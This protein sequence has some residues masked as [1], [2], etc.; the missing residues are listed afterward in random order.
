[1]AT[2]DDKG[3]VDPKKAEELA[4]AMQAAKFAADAAAQSFQRQLDIVSQLRD[5][6]SEMSATMEKMSQ[7]DTSTAFA[8]DKLRAYAKSS[9]E[10][11]QVNTGM[12]GAFKKLATFLQ[13]G[14]S[15]AIIIGTAALTGLHQGFK[16]LVAASTSIYG[17][18]TGIADGAFSV[19]KSILSI[20]FKLM[21][22]LFKMAENSGGTEL[23]QALENIRK[24]FGSFKSVSSSAILTT[25]KSLKGFSDTGL[26]AFRVF[27]N[28]AQKM[29][30]VLKLATEMGP[31][32]EKNADEFRSNGGAL[33]AYQKGLG[34]SGEQ[35]QFVANAAMRMGVPMS[36]VLNDTTKQAQGMAKA[37]G[38]DAK[39]IS[40]DMGK[41]MQDLSHFGH[42]SSKEMSIAVTYAN[43]LGLSIDKLTGVMDA[44]S[45]FDQAAESVSKL[46]ETFHTNID[47]TKLMSA[48][49]PAE[50]LEILR[51]EFA[52]TGKDMSNL[53]FQE[54]LLIKQNTGLEDS[55]LDAAFAS[56]N[57]GVSLDKISKQAAV[58]EK[59]TLSQADAMHELSSSIERMVQEAPK[60]GGGIFDKFID[61]IFKGIESSQSFIDMMTNIKTVFREA[62]MS[63]VTLG[64][65]LVDLFPGVSKIFTSIGNLFNPAHFSKLFAGIL[66]SFDVFDALGSGKF[67]DFMDGIKKSFF[68]FFDDSKSSGKNLLDGFKTFGL[69]IVKIIGKIG[70]WAIPKIADAITSITEWIKNPKLPNTS[71]VGTGLMN[72]L[73]KPLE[74]AFNALKEKLVPALKDLALTIL[75]TLANGLLHTNTGNAILAG[76][77][78]VFFGPALVSALLGAGLNLVLKGTGKAIMMMLGKGMEDSGKET[79]GKSIT[80]ALSSAAE[81]S[82]GKG[83]ASEG[84]NAIKEATANPDQLKKAGDTK[85]NWSGLITFLVGIA[86]VMAI[87]LAAFWLALKIIKG[88]K[89]ADLALAAIVFAEVAAFVG[90]A[91]LLT[92]PLAI[93]GKIPFK[94]A[95]TGMGIVALVI[96]GLVGVVEVIKR[97][98]A[99]ADTSK[100]KAGVDALSS[101]SNVMMK[102]GVIV[103][104]AAL[105]GA[106]IGASLGA[107]LVVITGG[108]IVMG[109]VITA[110]GKG[111]VEIMKAMNE[112]K[113]D[114]AGLK[115]K[116]EG[117]VALI[118]GVSFM[119]SQISGILK[120][121]DFGTFESNES[122]IEKINSVSFMIKTLIDGQ[123]GKGGI[124]GV[125]VTIIDGLKDITPEKIEFARAFATVIT[126]VGSLME[127]TGKAASNLQAQ[128]THWY[129]S[130]ET[131]QKMIEVATKNA[132]LYISSAIKGLIPLI[133]VISNAAK[134]MSGMSGVEASGQMISSVISAISGLLTSITPN[135]GLFQKTVE[136]AN[137]E[138]GNTK[139]TSV[140]SEGIKSMMIYMTSVIDSMT[141]TLPKLIAK[142]IVISS[143]VAKFSP[144]QFK[145]VD[146]VID[147]IKSISSLTGGISASLSN[148]PKIDIK[149][150]DMS[151]VNITGAIPTIVDILNGM[152]TSLPELIASM[153]SITKSV[154]TGAAFGAQVEMI[155]TILNTIGKVS[156]IS[157]VFEKLPSGERGKGMAFL[158]GAYADMRFIMSALA[159]TS[160]GGVYSIDDIVN[161]LSVVG[162]KIS[163]I[164]NINSASAGLS[165]L[166]DQFGRLSKSM[167]RIS[168]SM[169]IINKSGTIGIGDALNGITAMVADIQK[170][171]NSLASLPK[172]KME[173]RLKEVA[174]K[175]S[176]GSHGVYSVQS[177]DVIINV[178]LKVVMDVD[179]VEQVIIGRHESIIRDRINFA[180][181]NS[182]GEG[183]PLTAN[184]L[185]KSQ[186]PNTGVDTGGATP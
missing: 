75:E 33:L 20:P 110:M 30:E 68:D 1:M 134:S 164:K 154:P 53:K 155:G 21:D 55:A 61:G 146:L 121:M 41:A 19:A 123:N 130:K 51:K 152:K 170:M 11:V 35:M 100:L 77:F 132:T 96:L 91:A 12:L 29:E 36:K 40:R 81:K 39:I 141:A 149:A 161:S 14:W 168:E 159:G 80:N 89:V 176:L 3:S 140:D 84:M 156:E 102:V 94:E 101:I 22:G 99:G 137:S 181:R 171:D 150:G 116:S 166:A 108:L 76:A 160:F 37:F 6:M 92:K 69:A 34:L 109:L 28:V 143:H 25:A 59:K 165:N 169:G 4:K 47:A 58:N 97:V 42:L 88:E 145:A 98:S 85:V 32:F 151:V 26:N 183:N 52:K 63:G 49:N 16:N 167:A 135:I 158:D 5:A 87:G 157:N 67:E 27:G 105:I 118:G 95:L 60:S 66:K 133:D 17:V 125:I 64:K 178:E 124:K 104:E 18:F 186:G 112:I 9:K 15:K 86:A 138:G 2:V 54:R 73:M 50:K 65:K 127:I 106:G 120:A 13:G 7:C 57:M 179:K 175:L 122:K 136:T 83:G 153:I 82:S 139:T 48:Q 31:Q 8:P 45:T 131:D 184:A 23:Q 79:I 93:A 117:F 185:I 103:A 38:L 162:G 128:S 71:G 46:N 24:E 90:V 43:K 142:I 180:I 10:I 62:T 148:A 129:Q 115:Q 119:M 147:I 78:V 144:A 44:T 72:A 163:N 113:G 70:E 126:S 114:P 173:A 177:K 107:G 174:G 74:G 172:I 111:V 56:K 182:S